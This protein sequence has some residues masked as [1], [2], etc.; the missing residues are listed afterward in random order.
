MQAMPW[1]LVDNL[2]LIKIDNTQIPRRVELSEMSVPFLWDFRC[3]TES[4]FRK[5]ETEEITLS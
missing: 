2:S 5:I 3:R 1:F 4:N